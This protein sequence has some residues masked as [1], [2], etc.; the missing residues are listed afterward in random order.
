VEGK[1]EIT[2]QELIAAL[3]EAESFDS[4]NALTVPELT[5]ILHHSDKWIRTR[6]TKLKEEGKIQVVTVLRENLAGVVTPRTAYKWR[7]RNTGK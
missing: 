2:E 3:Q 1:I 7:E 6:L 5:H 4:P